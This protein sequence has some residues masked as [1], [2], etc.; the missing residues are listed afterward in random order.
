MP[1]LGPRG[2]LAVASYPLMLVLALGAEVSRVEQGVW[3][4]DFEPME[5]R[6]KELNKDQDTLG[7]VAPS[8]AY[9][10]ADSGKW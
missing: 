10:R 6:S 9:R 8:N 4:R 5:K 7:V 1:G 2:N 3:L